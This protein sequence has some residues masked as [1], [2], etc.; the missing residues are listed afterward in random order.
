MDPNIDTRLKSI[1]QKLEENHKMLVKIR[2]VQINAQ[3]FKAFYWT[4][5]I[6][7][8][9]GAFYYIQPYINDLINAYTGMQE[10]Q[11]QLQSAFPEL[12]SL[13]DILNQLK[14]N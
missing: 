2:R 6:L 1:E 7:A 9:F 11:S 14:G 5:I 4:I 3:I 12:G 10:T 13:T 8:T